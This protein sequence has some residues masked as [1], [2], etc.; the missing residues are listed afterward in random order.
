MLVDILAITFEEK[1]AWC[2]ADML[3]PVPLHPSRHYGR[4]YNQAEYIAL[5]LGAVLG[6][7][8]RSDIIARTRR[9]KPQQT[10]PAEARA[11]NIKGVFESIDSS[12]RGERVLIVDDVVTSGQTALEVSRVLARSGYTPVGVISLAHGQ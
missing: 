7:S 2:E 1:L 8:V 4:G 10:L 12:E 3:V 9:R 11:R 6:V 5:T